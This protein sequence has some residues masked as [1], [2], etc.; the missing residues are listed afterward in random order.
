M[1]GDRPG[2]QESSNMILS[3]VEGVAAGLL[4]LVAIPSPFVWSTER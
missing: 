4:P 2:E 3:R 1:P